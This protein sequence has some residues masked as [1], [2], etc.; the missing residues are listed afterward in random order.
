MG[1]FYRE[2]PYCSCNLDPGEICDCRK[3]EVA[4]GSTGTTSLKM[5]VKPII[6]TSETIIPRSGLFVKAVS[7]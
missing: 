2:C 5:D 4:P 6:L 7:V 3:K 1:A